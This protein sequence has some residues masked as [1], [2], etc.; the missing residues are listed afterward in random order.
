MEFDDA[1][2][3][4]RWVFSHDDMRFHGLTLAEQRAAGTLGVLGQAPFEQPP[5]PA[6]N[7][8]LVTDRALYQ[9]D[10]EA[11]RILPRARLPAG[12]HVIGLAEAGDRI[13]LLGDRALYLYD[14]RDLETSDALLR[15]RWRVPTPGRSGLL[16]QADVME[17][18]DG[19]LVSF[20]FTNDVFFG[21]GQPFQALVRVDE[22]GRATEVGRRELPSGYSPLYLQRGWI[23]SP[24]LHG[25]KQQVLG[26]FAGYQSEFDVDPRTQPRVVLVAAATLLLASL[27]LGAWRARRTELSAPARLAWVAA[28]GLVGLPAAMALWL[29]YPPRERL[30][31]LP[32]TRLALALLLLA[33]AS[34]ASAAEPVEARTA[35][36]LKAW[37][38]VE[39]ARPRAPRLERIAFLSMPMLREARLAPDGASVAA[40]VENGRDRSLWLADAAH[41]KGR[42]LLGRSTA[43]SLYFSNDGRWLFLVSPTQVYALA[44]AGQSGSGALAKVGERSNRAF[45]GVDP[46]RPG[47]VLLLESPPRLSPLPKRWRLWRAEIGGRTTLLYES[48]RNIVDFAFAPDGE[49]SHLKLTVGETRVIV[50]QVAKGSWRALALCPD[51]R[52]CDFVATENGGRDLVAEVQPSI[53]T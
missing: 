40:L 32:R 16:A 24:L 8:M 28:C 2:R 23:A 53:A 30:A 10:E 34:A 51:T 47:A 41:P 26:W 25:L 50:H 14:A 36:E 37:A 44:M 1:T 19:A 43:Q 4:V 17:L 48:L 49:L 27:L 42:R 29:L 31:P 20:T 3:R 12:E 22:Q 15:P 13:A 46:W 33:G 6:G 7:N 35:A 38:A 5:L 45:A 11:G 39:Q 52:Q 9:Y 18:L 21:R